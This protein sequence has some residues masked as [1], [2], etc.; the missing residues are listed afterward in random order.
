MREETSILFCLTMK[1]SGARSFF[2]SLPPGNR[3][4]VY[5]KIPFSFILWDVMTEATGNAKAL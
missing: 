4:S 3:L 1:T 5:N 2:F